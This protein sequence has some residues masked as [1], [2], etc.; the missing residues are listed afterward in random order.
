MR[1]LFATSILA[2]VDILALPDT[3]QPSYNV[4]NTRQSDNGQRALLIFP[5]VPQRDSLHVKPPTK[6][7][8]FQKGQG[9]QLE[10]CDSEG[11]TIFS[12]TYMPT[13]MSR[14]H[15]REI[16][17]DEV[18]DWNNNLKIRGLFPQGSQWKKSTLAFTPQAHA[19]IN[20]YDW[21]LKDDKDMYVKKSGEDM[22]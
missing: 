21:I 20:Q 4:N 16:K 3:L 1:W 6:K 8:H 5:R 12:Q 7:C 15:D 14:V 19:E 9:R 10:D 13:V 17:P 18:E 22:V 11:Y 2:I